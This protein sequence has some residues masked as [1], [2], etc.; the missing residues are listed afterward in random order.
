MAYI[1][2]AYIY[3][4]GA[5]TAEFLHLTEGVWKMPPVWAITV[6]AIYRP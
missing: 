2:M 5:R 3:L 1:V 6:S 4:T